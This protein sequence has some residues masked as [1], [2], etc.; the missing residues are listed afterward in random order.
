MPSLL[1]LPGC[2]FQ[3]LL[4]VR[5]FLYAQA[6]ATG[7]VIW[8]DGRRWTRKYKRMFRG[9]SREGSRWAFQ[10]SSPSSGWLGK[11]PS[12][13]TTN[14]REQKYLSYLLGA[15][16]HCILVYKSQAVEVMRS[17]GCLS[18]AKPLL[19]LYSAARSAPARFQEVQD[20]AGLLL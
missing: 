17:T 1:C 12:F 18:L 2:E 10:A 7:G 5:H 14:Y 13:S 15:C 20:L 3:S 9:M 11:Q 16:S 4:L 19:C 6:N 8:A